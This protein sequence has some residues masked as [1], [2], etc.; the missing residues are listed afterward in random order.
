MKRRAGFTLIETVVALVIAAGMFLLVT[1]TERTFLR[2][3]RRD[4]VAWYQLVQL[5]EQSGRYRV[6][7]AVDDVLLIYDQQELKTLRLS[8]DRKQ[9]LKLTN[10]QGQGYYPLLRSVTAIHWREVKSGVVALK[11]KRE[12]LPWQETLVDLRGIKDS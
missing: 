8:V 7:A 3:I 10:T 1:G 11:I 12:G 2:P 4:P 6:T 9:T 5:L